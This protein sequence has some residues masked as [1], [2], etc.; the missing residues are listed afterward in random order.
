MLQ[1]KGKDLEEDARRIQVKL[2]RMQ[3][4]KARRKEHLFR[5]EK[6]AAT[7][8]WLESNRTLKLLF[9]ICIDIFMIGNLFRRQ[10]W[11]PIAIEVTVQNQDVAACL[12]Q[13]V[14]Y[15]VWKMYVVECQGK[16]MT[17]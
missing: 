6:L 1:Q 7:Y 12:E 11:G 2:N 16:S 14:S 13:H 9:L 4:E 15:N 17:F 8:Q 3:D 10:V 5:N